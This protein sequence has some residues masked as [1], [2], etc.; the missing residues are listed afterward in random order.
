MAE[1]VVT[2]GSVGLTL[3]GTLTTPESVSP[4]PAVMMLSGSGQSD[5]DDT[6]SR[7]PINLFPQL[8]GPLGEIGFVTF[9]YDKRGVGASEGDYLKPVSVFAISAPCHR[10]VCS[11]DL[12]EPASSTTPAIDAAPAASR[13]AI[14][15]PSLC[16]R[17]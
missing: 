12:A 7:L 10:S 15:A 4:A 11:P 13:I 6:V 17:T 1:Q 3:T 16:P 14:S 5:R 9:R 8:A 2:F